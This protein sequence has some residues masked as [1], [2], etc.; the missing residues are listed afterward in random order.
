MLTGLLALGTG[1]AACGSSGGGGGSK[2]G[3]DTGDDTSATTDTGDTTDTTGGETTDTTDTTDDTT[4]TGDTC[5]PF[6]QPGWECGPDGCSGTCGAGCAA[7]DECNNATHVCQEKEVPVDLPKYGAACG[8]KGDC[9]PFVNTP[10]GFQDNPNWPA[11]MNA[12]CASGQCF[13]PSCTKSCTITKDQVDHSGT[14][15]P[16]GIDDPDAAFDDC[17][18][19][20]DG[21]MGA[22]YKCVAFAPPDQGQ[23]VNF[24]SPGTTF[25]PCVS[26]TDCPAAETCQLLYVLGEYSTRCAAAPKA[27]AKIGEFCNRNPEEGDVKYCETTLCFGPGCLGFCGDDNDCLT[28]T[29]SGGKCAKGGGDCANDAECS[30]MYCYKQFEIFGTSN[31]DIKMDICWGNQCSGNT[32]CAGDDYFCRINFNGEFNENADWEHLCA[33]AAPNAAKLGEECEDDAT[34]N[35]PKPP[36]AGPCLNNGTCSAICDS[37]ADCAGG[38]TG[39]LCSANASGVDFNNDEI[40]DKYIP[41]GLCVDYPGT[42]SD[43]SADGDCAGSPTPEAC[44]FYSY[45]QADGA[46]DA[47]G[48]CAETEPGEGDVGDAC[49]GNSGVNCKS[50][51]CLGSQGDQPGFCTALCGS[52]SDFPAGPQTL[53]Q[54]GGT[55]NMF[56][57]GYLYSFGFDVDSN[58]DTVYVPLCR[59]AS[60]ETS[61]LTDCSADFKCG[62]NEACQAIGVAAG[63]TGPAKAEFLCLGAG[64]PDAQGAFQPSTA[65]MGDSCDITF[66][67]NSPGDFCETNYCLPDAGD[68]KGYCGGLCKE[69]SDCTGA[70]LVCDDFILIDRIGTDNDV[71]TKV[72]RKEASCIPCQV[73]TDC[74]GT[75]VCVNVGSVGLLADRRCAPACTV[76]ADCNGTDGGS[77]CTESI[78]GEGKPEAKFSCEPTCN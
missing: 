38:G 22:N 63:A 44:D 52:K 25:A 55:Y 10:D 54:F 58:E 67:S 53:G 61:P 21:P 71:A 37:T 41:L 66:E 65:K 57:F 49:G 29:C 40:D 15:G 77:T 16:D 19:A 51:F 60:A 33:A 26:N 48:I 9:Q 45:F 30:A 43:C 24:C 36:C 76:D 3:D 42:Q 32:D 72:C 23:P 5:V 7:G 20:V 34:D 68:D 75:N 70:G 69:D 31:P 59:P 56:C 8:R 47:K 62:A 12:Q 14:A 17:A 50:G 4:D 1:L 78:D 2:G 13:E 39:M 27:P 35:I 18:G 64:I 28:D 11:C 6:C 74:T 46:L 73:D